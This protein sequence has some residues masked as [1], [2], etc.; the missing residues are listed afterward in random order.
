MKKSLLTI[1]IMLALPLTANAT[2][3]YNNTNTP[4]AV[5]NNGTVTMATAS[6]P[7]MT[8]TIGD[9]DDE[10]IASTAYVKGAYNDSIA[11]VNK[12]KNELTS[13]NNQVSIL[14][15]T[16]GNKQDQ[17]VTLSE[18]NGEQP[19]FPLVFSKNDID[20]DSFQNTVINGSN[21]IHY[22]LLHES[23][24]DVVDDAISSYLESKYSNSDTDQ[25]LLTTGAAL[26]LIY[27]TEK[28][29][30][31][32][33]FL[34]LDTKQLQMTTRINNQ[35]QNISSTVSQTIGQ[36]PSATSLVSEAGVA[37]YVNNK[38]VEI[39]TT[40]DDDTAKTEVAFVTAQ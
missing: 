7:Y 27:Q 36:T 37:N 21:F 16:I 13:V 2:Y 19:I 26:E 17:L 39:Y 14:N 35:S 34:N 31:D 11:A 18:T 23:E 15:N 4:A 9:D 33:M 25:Y 6:G 30:T 8:A 38:R 40:W 1:A 3:T 5:A 10:H 29:I 22:G 32:E 24:R 28:D 12:V 20:G